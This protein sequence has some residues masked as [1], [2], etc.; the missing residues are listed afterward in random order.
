M[1]TLYE[2]GI[3]I[4]CFLQ[5]SHILSTLIWVQGL[6]EAGLFTRAD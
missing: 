1:L 2:A 6:R 5:I 4:D 3:K